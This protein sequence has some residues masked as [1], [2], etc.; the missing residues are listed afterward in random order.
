[1]AAID[2][3]RPYVAAGS[4]AGFGSLFA[5]F[6]GVFTSW[7]QARE[8]RKALSGLSDRE[9]DDIGL[10]RADIDAITGRY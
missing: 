1:M 8:T 6:A 5:T 3:T 10:S 4:A 9:L 7:M 2:Q